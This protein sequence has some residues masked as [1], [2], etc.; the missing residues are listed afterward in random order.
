MW[1]EGPPCTMHRASPTDC[2]KATRWVLHSND[3]A[4]EIEKMHTQRGELDP[5]C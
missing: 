1:T 5:D 2:H 4:E 3:I